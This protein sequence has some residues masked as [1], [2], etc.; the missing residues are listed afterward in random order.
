M[1]VI[2][3]KE[4]SQLVGLCRSYDPF[5]QYIDSYK[6]EME[7]VRCNEAIVKAFNEIVNKFG[8]ECHYSI[9]WTCENKGGETATALEKYLADK[10]VE[11]EAKKVWTDDEIKNLIQTNDKVLY[12][13]LKKLYD[14]Q[15]ADEKSV[16][17]TVENNG[18]GFNGVDAPILTSIAQ[19][20]NKK[21]YLSDKQK[22][23]VRKKLVKYNKQL[24]KLANA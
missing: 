16:G 3:R 17:D 8:I 12:G 7:A 23:L 11:V 21:G 22:A 13:A 15:T 4:F 2:S 14:C 10:G 20:L 1:K 6:Q 19:F 5:T 24:T 9:P 18:V